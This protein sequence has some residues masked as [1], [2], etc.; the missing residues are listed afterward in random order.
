MDALNT[1]NMV[2]TVYRIFSLYSSS[3]LFTFT[4]IFLFRSEPISKKR[5]F[6]EYNSNMH[7]N[8]LSFSDRVF[9]DRERENSRV[10]IWLYSYKLLRVKPIT[11]IV[12]VT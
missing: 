5:I 6:T 11:I 7:D 8:M 2:T 12:K 1:I 9:S 3:I 4:A 10:R